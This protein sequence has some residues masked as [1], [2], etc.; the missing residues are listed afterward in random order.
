M[1]EK[2]TSKVH[3]HTGEHRR[4]DTLGKEAEAS[5]WYSQTG[6]KYLGTS[7]D[8]ERRQMS[9]GHSP[10]SP[11]EHI[12][13]K[14]SKERKKERKGHSLPGEHRGISQETDGE[15]AG[16]LTLWIAQAGQIR[17]CKE[18]EQEKGTHPLENTEPGTNDKSGYVK[19]EREQG[20]LTSWIAQIEGQVRNPKE[21][22]S[23]ENIV[24]EDIQKVLQLT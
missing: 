5:K 17:T 23:H 15:R 12:R 7:Q 16:A 3:S 22:E 20:S 1:E 4:K 24:Q 14:V 10:P 6:G 21:S 8:M 11:R 19:R 9:E 2:H 13:G 18:S